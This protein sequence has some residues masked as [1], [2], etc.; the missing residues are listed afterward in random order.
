MTHSGKS[1]IHSTPP[2][3][4]I[5]SGPSGV[6]KD[7]VLTR[8]KATESQL[9]FIITMT[10]RTR[11]PR[12]TDGVDYRFV[13]KEVFERLLKKNELLESANVYGN[14][15]GVPKQPVRNALKEG[16]D[17]IVKVDVQGAATIKKILPNAIFIFLMPPSLDELKNRLRQ[18]YTEKPPELAIRLRA[19]AD[20]I[21][22][23]SK[24]DYLVMNNKDGLD[25][26]VEEIRAII[27][28][29]KHRVK[30]RQIIL[31]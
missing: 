24:F 19:A 25:I 26:A 3:F 22:Q 1:L 30:P 28:A 4:I 9:R 29:E 5:L 17:T 10:T 2:L 23:V 18:R 14:W 31:L 15:Y 20:E 16:K 21:K 8:L 12:E 27:T 11:R 6:G 7:A 13:S